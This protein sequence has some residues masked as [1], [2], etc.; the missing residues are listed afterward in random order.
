M[1]SAQGYTR[2]FSSPP[3][4]D[5]RGSWCDI[6]PEVWEYLYNFTWAFSKHLHFVFYYIPLCLLRLCQETIH[7]ARLPFL[8]YLIT[9]C[10]AA[11]CFLRAKYLNTLIVRAF[12]VKLK[13]EAFIQ[14][15]TCQTL[16][17][18]RKFTLEYLILRLKFS[19]T[20]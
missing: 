12:Q 19:D 9:L 10:I 16:Q 15:E 20:C 17:P 1:K 18:I 7:K 3:E 8:G 14:E 6:L 4:M 2:L 5:F 11:N 13:H